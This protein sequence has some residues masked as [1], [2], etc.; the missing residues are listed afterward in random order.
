MLKR[1]LSDKSRPGAW[2][3]PGGGY[4]EGEQI[5]E[6]ASREILEESGL[7][8]VSLSPIYIDNQINSSIELYA[9]ENVFVVAYE[10]REWKG[11][12][13]LSDEHIEYKWVTQEEFVKLDFGSDGGF[14][15]EAV[16]HL[17][18]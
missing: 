9:G 7:T 6:A 5:V 11:Q 18:A 17:P 3:T 16:K 2:D 4:E 10:C 1:P 15:A 13:K 12:V 8:A 14:F